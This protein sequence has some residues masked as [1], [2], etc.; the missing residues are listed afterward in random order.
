ILGHQ[1][2]YLLTTK[3]LAKIILSLGYK[4]EEII[5]YVKINYPDYPIEFAIEKEPLGTAGALKQALGLVEDDNV[6]VLNCDDITDIDLAKLEALGPNVIC[7]AHPRLPF[8]LVT[9]ENGYAKFIEKP[10]LNDWVS[11]GWYLFAKS[12]LDRLLPVKGS[13]EYDVFPKMKLKVYKH[14]GFWQ[15]LNTKKDILEFEAL[16]V[17]RQAKNGS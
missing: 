15:P 8:G 6:L 13:L 4:A 17:G 7:V 5:D 11:C 14:D 12:D 2:D 10:I 3:K 1:L 9:E 16:P